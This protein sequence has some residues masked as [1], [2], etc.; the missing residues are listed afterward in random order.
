MARLAASRVE[1]LARWTS[2]F[3]RLP[4]EL[5]IGA[6]SRRHRQL[7]SRRSRR[8]GVLPVLCGSCD[9]GDL[10]PDRE[11]SRESASVLGGGDVIAA[12][13][14]EIVDLIVGRE[15]PWCLAG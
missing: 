5:S 10:S 11:G 4:K 14:E 12:E 2:S 1:K 3:F 6:L 9:I 13:V 8:V 7:V 15:E